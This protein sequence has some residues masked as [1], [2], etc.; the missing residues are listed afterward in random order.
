ME[1]SLAFLCA[2]DIFSLGWSLEWIASVAPDALV[3]MQ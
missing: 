1:L 3:A 2:I